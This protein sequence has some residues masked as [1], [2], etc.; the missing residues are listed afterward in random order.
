MKKFIAI[1]LSALMLM[2]LLSGCS[3]EVTV[4]AAGLQHMTLEG[5]ATAM[6]KEGYTAKLVPDEH[7]ELPETLTVTMEDQGEQ[8]YT[9][10]PA[11]GALTFPEVTGS[12]TI[13]GAATESIIDTWAG[14]V[15]F[16]EMLTQEMAADPTAAEYFSFSSFKLDLTMTFDAEGVCTLTVDEE[17]ARQ[18][19]DTMAQELLDGMVKLLDDLL[20]QQG[21]DM[22]TEDYLAASG[23]TLEDLKTQLT[24]EMSVEDMLDELSQQGNYK[25]Q[26]G[27]LLISDDLDS[28]PEEDD[29]CPYTL[30]DGVL[31][32]EASEDAAGEEAAAYMFPLVLNR[33]G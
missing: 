26:D 16:T 12:I 28:E 8:T 33:V 23:M 7:Y 22:T 6:T 29:A 24:A 15:D 1:A 13:A 14:T 17:S 10:D 5:A 2:S 30:T 32:I 20:R 27:K 19:I 25:L 11:T 9:Y 31:T 3:K 21:L 18:A 4:D